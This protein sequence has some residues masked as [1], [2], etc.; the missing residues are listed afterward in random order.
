MGWTL[1]SGESRLNAPSEKAVA[2]EADVTLV[3]QLQFGERQMDL[4]R[5]MERPQ[6]SDCPCSP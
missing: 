2:A 4:Q 6:V 1:H 5:G 3:A